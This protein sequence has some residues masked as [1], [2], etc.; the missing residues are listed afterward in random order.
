MRRDGNEG[1]SQ[2]KMNL[3]ISRYSV[4]LV[5]TA[6]TIEAILSMIEL[7]LGA[8]DLKTLHNVAP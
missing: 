4:Q 8:Q 7:F 1:E 5:G 6:H 2:V 3:R